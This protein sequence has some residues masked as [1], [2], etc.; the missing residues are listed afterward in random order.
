MRG[1]LKAEVGISADR[2]IAFSH[3]R[4]GMSEADIVAAGIASVSA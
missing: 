3:W 2:M 4:R 1:F